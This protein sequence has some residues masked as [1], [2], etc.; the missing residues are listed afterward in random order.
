M[1]GGGLKKEII[2]KLLEAVSSSL[3]TVNVYNVTINNS[4]N[5]NNIDKQ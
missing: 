5:N 3:F 1:K 4:N 2:I